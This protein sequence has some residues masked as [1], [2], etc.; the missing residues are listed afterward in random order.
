M[1]IRP[2]PVN[3][4]RYL[5]AL[6]LYL[7]EDGWKEIRTIFPDRQHGLRKREL[8]L[9]HLII[10]HIKMEGIFRRVYWMFL[11]FWNIWTTGQ[12]FLK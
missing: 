7:A 12:M 8:R 10:E 4:V 5:R 2:K 3:M 9:S 11:H 1:F 6:F